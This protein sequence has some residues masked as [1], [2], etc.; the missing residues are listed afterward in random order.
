M[1]KRWFLS[2][3]M[4]CSHQDFNFSPF[5]T[6]CKYHKTV[7]W[8]F[9]LHQWSYLNSWN[10]P[11][12]CAIGEES[13]WNH[14]GSCELLTGGFCTKSILIFQLNFKNLWN[15]ACVVMISCKDVTNYFYVCSPIY[16]NCVKLCTHRH[17]LVVPMQRCF[18]PDFYIYASMFF[19]YLYTYLGA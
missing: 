7:I 13:H 10:D 14:N 18:L 9:T 4:V 8:S 12:L 6:P 19:D 1:A 17:L 15:G 2:Y 16:Y 11:Y 5:L 3:M